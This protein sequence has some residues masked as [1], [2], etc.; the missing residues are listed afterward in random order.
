[1]KDYIVEKHEVKLDGEWHKVSPI[2][3]T[4]SKIMFPDPRPM[5]ITPAPA[6]VSVSGAFAVS[7]LMIHKHDPFYRTSRAMR[8]VLNQDLDI[9]EK[10]KADYAEVELSPGYQYA[11]VILD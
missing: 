8:V 7:Y 4:D 3:N 9:I 5:P 11:T 6:A 2:L 1:M 10:I